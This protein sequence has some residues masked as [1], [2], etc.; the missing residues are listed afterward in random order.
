MGFSYAATTTPTWSPALASTIE[1]LEICSTRA[2][3][4]TRMW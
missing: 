4:R 2:T 1:H 3:R